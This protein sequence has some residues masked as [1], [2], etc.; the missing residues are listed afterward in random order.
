[1][2]DEQL[3]EQT[4][5]KILGD[6]EDETLINLSEA[7]SPIF[8]A[9]IHRHI[10]SALTARTEECARVIESYAT[11]EMTPKSLHRCFRQAA[12]A[13]RQLGKSG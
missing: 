7:D 8:R 2:T 12:T 3:T 5:R 11:I 10:Q 13:I 6:I 4:Y 9:M 1:M